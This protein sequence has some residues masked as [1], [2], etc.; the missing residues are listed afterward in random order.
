MKPAA[1]SGWKYNFGMHL[2]RY[3]LFKV[4]G[5]TAFISLF[6]VAY[7][8]ILYATASRASMMPLT[9]ID[10]LV[11]FHPL[12]FYPYASLWVYA[13]L[14]PIIMPSLRELIV[15][16]LWAAALCITGL[17]CFWFWPT[18][19]PPLQIDT[20]LYTGFSLIHGLDASGNACPSLHIATAVFTAIWLHRLL[21]ES[22]TP[23]W[24]QVVNWFWCAIIAW[25]T[26]ATGQHVALDVLG[27]GI[28]GLVFARA[29]LWRR[30]A[31]QRL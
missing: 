25:S 30:A 5:I 14:A 23:R 28:L 8:H 4:A 7:F 13:G 31:R 11:G 3:L 29:S 20:S 12:A 1:R 27:G 21:A 24:L 6:F 22:S 15:Y 2:R 17:A 10:D 16:G 18:A 19:V 26:V 9:F